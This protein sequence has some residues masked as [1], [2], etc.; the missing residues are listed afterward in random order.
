MPT[1]DFITCDFPDLDG[2][3]KQLDL[4]DENVNKALR[5]AMSSSADMIVSAQ[6]RLISLKSRRLEAHI[7][8]GEIK[9]LKNGGLSITTGYQAEAFRTDSNGFNAGVVGMTFEYGRPG[10]GVRSK[11]TMTQ[12]RHGK[13]LSVRKGKIDA[14]PHIRRGFDE[15]VQKA[16][17]HL[18]EAYN[19]EVNR[20]GG[21]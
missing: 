10:S 4:F 14:V 1:E 18:I 19:N 6:K 7:K 2:F 11:E 9:T 17:E 21:T 16:A 13:R 12:T 15:T 20:L 3:I 8:K 5:N